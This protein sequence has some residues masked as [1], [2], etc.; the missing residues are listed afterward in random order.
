MRGRRRP[1]GALALLGLALLVTG[2]GLGTREDRRRAQEIADERHPGLL[3]VVG[4]R[5]LFPR[6][7]GSEVSLSVAD[8]PDAVV[9][10]RIDADSGVCGGAPC[11]RALDVALED[12]RAAARDLRLLRAALRECGHTP[13]AVRAYRSSVGEPWIEARLTNDN[14]T[15]V[16]ERLGECLRG[17]ASAYSPADGAAP[18]RQRAVT[19][20]IAAPGTAPDAPEN[21]AGRG[22]TLV[23]LT[24]RGVHAALATRPSYAVT[25]TYRNGVLD[26]GSGAVRLVRP[27]R[28]RRAFERAVGD[29][30][31]AWLAPRHPGAHQLRPHGV[32]RLVPGRV[33]RLWGH[34]LFCDRSHPEER[35][36]AGAARC[37]GDHA[38]R[39]TTDLDGS[40]VG[41]PRVIR[42][43]REGNGPLRLPPE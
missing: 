23:R 36:R 8:D 12:A 2:C 40:L 18:S 24:E 4:A 9:R 17:W 11:D 35:G 3:R 1:R 31:A 39:V 5:T 20:H 25:W 38:V 37:R 10:L 6:T 42:D 27:F 43:V 28:E 16:L 21:A 29:H 19:V 26:A 13:R 34:V 30:T 41:E 7:S 22:P 15:G 33:D 32:V 14:V